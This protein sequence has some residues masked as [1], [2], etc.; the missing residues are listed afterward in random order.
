MPNFFTGE[1]TKEELQA[2][3]GEL[4]GQIAG[5]DDQVSAL[6]AELLR[7]RDVTAIANTAR[8][9]LAAAESSD[10]V[11][12]SARLEAEERVKDKLIGEK[13][14]G[15][16]ATLLADKE[17]EL[18]LKY[19]PDWVEE[20]RK[21]QDGMLTRDGTYDK[22]D[23]QVRAA[24]V[25]EITDGLKE[26]HLEEVESELSSEDAQAELLAE[27]KRKLAE[28]GDLDEIRAKVH[29]RMEKAAHEKALEEAK[30]EIEAEVAGEE[31]AYKAALKRNWRDGWNGREYAEQ[32][33]TK[34]LRIWEKA[35]REEIAK[36][37]D[38]EEYLGLLRE[39]AE[40]DKQKLKAEQIYEQL[41]AAFFNGGI[42]TSAIPKD[43]SVV[44]YLGET[45]KK[46]N[47]NYDSYNRYDTNVPK[48]ITTIQCVRKIKLISN[49]D[50]TYA[51]TEDSLSESAN[52]YVADNAITPGTIITIGHKMIDKKT[53]S[54]SLEMR[55]IR[56][57]P[58][59]YDDDTSTPNITASH[60][61]V[62][63]VRIGDVYARK[64]IKPDHR[65][66]VKQ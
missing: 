48:K 1:P 41:V 42:D 51:V 34:A 18:T 14:E 63:D 4:E 6:Q 9:A 31:D 62:A 52:E 23:V 16:V 10:E 50:G 38:D 54:E 24:K 29:K 25:E 15:I 64:D 58:F 47:P 45:E 13:K 7:E 65:V 21:K 46:D 5:Y 19:G 8:A 55:L 59:F 11:F 22:I 39:K 3:I 30:A 40:Q 20:E 43:T 35:A 60:Y 53:K 33:R 2:R 36:E 12:I 49:G 27:A 57:V 28:S 26:K 66:M 56:D 32:A 61:P 44:I 37:I 17:D